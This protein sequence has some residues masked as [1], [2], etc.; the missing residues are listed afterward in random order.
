MFSLSKQC[1][2]RSET[3]RFLDD[4]I[5]RDDENQFVQQSYSSQPNHYSSL[6]R[7][8][9]KEQFD[10]FEEKKKQLEI[11]N[12]LLKPRMSQSPNDV[13]QKKNEKTK[14]IFF[15][16]LK[17]KSMRKYLENV[18]IQ[19][20]QDEIKDET[21][22]EEIRNSKRLRYQET[23]NYLKNLKLDWKNFKW[24]RKDKWSDFIDEN[25]NYHKMNMVRS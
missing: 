20:F 14:K 3:I 4:F 22:Y 11:Q 1:L 2:E 7:E 18:A 13:K 25:F 12:Q 10:P 21:I 17:L 15:F 6:L 9:R 24:K 5:P 8:E 23:Q 19:N 16:F